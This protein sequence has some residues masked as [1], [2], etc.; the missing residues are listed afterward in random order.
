MPWACMPCSMAAARI[1]TVE[2]NGASRESGRSSRITSHQPQVTPF[3]AFARS[4]T[5]LPLFFVPASF[6]FNRLRT[7]LRKHR[8]W[9]TPPQTSRVTPDESQVASLP[10]F[11]RVTNH[12]SRP[13]TPFRINTCISVASKR[14]YLPLESTLT[15]K[16]GE[17]EGGSFE[18]ALSAYGRG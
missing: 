3:H 13:I 14:L 9:H 18:F 15:K 10:R 8:G 5:L 2:K 7:L 6:I 16:P 1:F 17:G 11:S 12:E 4:S